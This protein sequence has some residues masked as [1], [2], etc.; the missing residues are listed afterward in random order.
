MSLAA[1]ELH[2]EK[3]YWKKQF[4][5]FQKPLGFPCDQPGEGGS[6]TGELALHIG[7][8]SSSTLLKT[9]NGSDT[10]LLAMLIGCTAVLLKKYTDNDD[11]TIGT[12]VDRSGDGKKVLNRIIPL[13]LQLAGD[14]TVKET[15]YHSWDV[16]S[17][18]IEHQNYPVFALL[19]D[20]GMAETTELFNV[21][22]VLNTI[23][24]P[25]SLQDGAPDLVFFF[26]RDDA[27]LKGSLFYNR[28][29][30]GL[31]TVEKISERFGRLLEQFV[32]P[33][34]TLRSMSVL[35]EEEKRELF[36]LSAGKAA[37]PA[38]K[39]M[40]DLFHEVVDQNPDRIALVCGDGQ[41]SYGELSARG[42]KIAAF[43]D[44]LRTREPFCVGVCLPRGSDFIVAI[45]GILKCGGAYLPLDP[46]APEGRNRSMVEQS[47]GSFV[48]SSKKVA[49]PNG[50]SAGD[51]SVL[52][53]E[54]IFEWNGDVYNT[55]AGKDS[56]QG[57]T[58]YIIYTS[59]STGSPKGVRVT[60]E[61]A[62]NLIY[63]MKQIV[64]DK[65]LHPDLIM[66]LLSN[67]IFDASVQGIFGSLL[68]GGRLVIADDE[69]RADGRRLLDLYQKYGVVVSDGAPVHLRLIHAAMD[70]GRWE[71]L[72]LRHLIIGGDVLHEKDIS[73]FRRHAGLAGVRIT[74]VYGP[75]ECT[76]NATFYDVGMDRMGESNAI[77]P[78]GRPLP[79][80]SILLLDKDLE[81]VPP[82]TAGEIYIGGAGVAAGYVDPDA[83]KGYFFEDLFDTGIRWYRTG[84]IARWGCDD[85]LHFIKRQDTQVKISGYRIELTEIKNALLSLE[86]VED[87]LV[88]VIDKED[89]PA[90]CAYVTGADDVSVS[91]YQER[92]GALLPRYMLPPFI[93]RLK[94]WPRTHAGKIDAARLPHPRDI[95]PVARKEPENEWQRRMLAIWKNVLKN[96]NIGV[97]DN[98]FN[99][100]GDSIKLIKLL[101]IVR[102]ELNITFKLTEIYGNESIEKL[103][104]LV[105][106]P[107]LEQKAMDQIYGQM[108]NMKSD[109]LKNL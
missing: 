76:V 62:I 91:F 96:D 34:R 21:A 6:A 46:A 43:L 88:Q 60:H 78:I 72:A 100:G 109:L 84:D 10:R 16:L 71:T 19:Q 57:K 98:F 26:D 85:T 5:G 65:Y 24:N 25:D 52:Y 42:D 30:F 32:D 81:P 27:G 59:G 45:I 89:N 18:A 36:S 83:D 48:L 93:V 68:N 53:L 97:T 39:N 7:G 44:R 29:R 2:R 101:G 80:Y 94:T 35:T 95:L 58:A 54:D 70:E 51:G 4:A 55:I 77:V 28:K 1:R 40:I 73:A 14:L 108:E 9:S 56:R 87:A 104:R 86:G 31:A 37:V 8:E 66:G 103:Y 74:N 64:F 99:V 33:G 41:I 92:L 47:G 82:E 49:R 102:S 67:F 107:G 106:R 105:N 79:G 12:P 20:L 38:G 11:L 50:L 15:I 3:A 69:Q 13:R 22:I 63:G 75:T 61:N 17:E 23:Q 90:V